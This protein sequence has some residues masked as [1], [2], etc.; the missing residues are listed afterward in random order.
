MEI[1]KGKEMEREHEEREWQKKPANERLADID[2]RILKEQDPARM[3]ELTTKRQV[4]S[5]DLTR[6]RQA[7]IRTRLAKSRDNDR[8]R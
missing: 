4:A 3:T 1:G 7:K 6:E 5:E 8:G 2:K